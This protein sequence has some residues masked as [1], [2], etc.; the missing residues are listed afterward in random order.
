MFQLSTNH[1]IKTFF[2]TFFPNNI[3]NNI[4]S[5]GGDKENIEN[6]YHSVAYLSTLSKIIILGIIKKNVFLVITS[7]NFDAIF[8][9][10]VL[11]KIVTF[12]AWYGVILTLYLLNLRKHYFSYTNTVL[13]F[14]IYKIRSEV[15]HNVKF[16]DLTIESLLEGSSH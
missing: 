3:S 16:L 7:N 15:I 2:R 1:L 10:L 5:Q 4:S 9:I 8:Y 12:K 13:N 14:L 6:N 11:K